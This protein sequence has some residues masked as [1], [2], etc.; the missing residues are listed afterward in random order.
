[1]SHD[2]RVTEL[3]EAKGHTDGEKEDTI[4][5]EALRRGP[6]HTGTD[7]DVSQQ[8]SKEDNFR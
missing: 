5:E 7:S 8:T 6:K 3:N 1:M 4:F 2:V